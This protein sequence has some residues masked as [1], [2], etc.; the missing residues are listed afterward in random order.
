VVLPCGRFPLRVIFACILIG[1][2][3]DQLENRFGVLADSGNG[4]AEPIP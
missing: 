4:D 2:A 1:Q 3:I